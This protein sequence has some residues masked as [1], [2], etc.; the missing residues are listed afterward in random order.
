MATMAAAPSPSRVNG[1]GRPTW[2]EKLQGLLPLDPQPRMTKSAKF[3]KI[4]VG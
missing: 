4:I 1:T 2:Q 3:W